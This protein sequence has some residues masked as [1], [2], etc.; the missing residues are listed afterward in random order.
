MTDL[1]TESLNKVKALQAQASVLE[2]FWSSYRAETSKGSCDKHE[3]CFDGD[4]R[5]ELFKIDTSFACHTGYFGHSGCSRFGGRFDEDI[6]RGAFIRAMNDNAELL[7][8]AAAHFI[9]ADADKLME[10]ARAELEGFQK[11]IDTIEENK[12]TGDNHEDHTVTS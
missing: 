5:W 1:T 11:L 12:P 4:D 6:V 9:K 3:A 10:K 8:K 2:E 7:F